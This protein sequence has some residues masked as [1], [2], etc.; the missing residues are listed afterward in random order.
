MVQ[1]ESPAKVDFFC[2]VLN[3]FELIGEPMDENEIASKN[4]KMPQKLH[5][6][7]N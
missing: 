4:F 3:D 7:K 5:Q 2:L 1:K 6:T